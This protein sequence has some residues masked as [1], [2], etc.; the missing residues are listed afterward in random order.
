MVEQAGSEALRQ[1]FSELES[2]SVDLQDLVMR[3]RMVPVGPTFRQFLRAARDLAVSHGK[4]A[5]LTTEGDAVEIDI[6]IVEHLK[7][8]L[9]H[10]VRNAVDHGIETPARRR[11]EGKDPCGTI[12]LRAWHEAGSIVIEVDDDGAGLDLARIAARARSLGRIEPDGALSLAEARALVCEPGFSTVETA[13][14]L[15]GRG[16]GL[17]V[18]RQRIEH[19][20]GGFDIRSTHGKGTTFTIRFPLT[21]AVL[22]AFTVSAADDEYLIP[23]DVVVECLAFSPS[24]AESGGCGVLLQ[25]GTALPYGRLRT[26]LR[27][28]GAPRQRE[29]LVVVRH[30]NDCFGLVV[31][32]ILGQHPAVIKPLGRY[33]DGLDCVAG[34]A[35]LDS[36]RVGLILD[37]AGLRRSIPQGDEARNATLG[38]QLPDPAVH[39]L[40]E[41]SNASL[42]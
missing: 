21:L 42:S 26:L 11:A 40:K 28:D 37:L 17:D 2:L 31:D 4:L 7:D 1:A 5:R 25:R 15:S 30:G 36:G 22:D 27:L 32:T 23:T 41:P 13:S 3:V 29:Q 20:G 19:L 33:L 9:T 14:E 16:V 6:T 39:E 12:A 34:C 35:V 38:P 24:T 10:L 8:V 18:V